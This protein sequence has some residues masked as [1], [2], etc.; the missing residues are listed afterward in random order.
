MSWAALDEAIARR[1]DAGRQTVFWWRDDDATVPGT[2][3][4]A[5]LD[6]GYSAGVPLGLAVIPE[7]AAPALFGQLRD[8]VWV[9]QHGADHCNRA[10]PD[11]KKNEFPRSE[12]DAA[13]LTRLARARERLV[14][15]GGARVLPALAPPWNRLRAG[16]VSGLPTAGI[17][18]L[19]A[20]G[21][22]ARAHPAEEVTQVNTHIDL[23][24]WRAGRG[25]IGVAQALEDARQHLDRAADEPIGWLTHHAEHERDALDFLARLFERSRRA[26]ARWASPR[27][28]WPAG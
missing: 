17:R 20:Y 3:L 19:S 16:L 11:E 5:L 10:A 12:E 15:M 14:R 22:R 9:L 28:W 6:L 18:G 24:A 21:P 23:V 25:F 26:G 4:K 27:E 2:R 7:S 13:A 1:H 8:E